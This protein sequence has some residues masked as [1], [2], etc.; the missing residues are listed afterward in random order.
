[1][2]IPV[3][4]KVRY[5]GSA[6]FLP[7]SGSTPYGYFDNDPHF[8]S[9]IVSATKWAAT[10]MGYPIVDIELVDVNFFSRFEEAVLEYG[11]QVNQFNIRNNMYLLQG[12]STSNRVTQKNIQGSGVVYQSS[13]AQD[14]GVELGV[15]G[16]VDWK[17][18][19]FA[20]QTGSDGG[21]R[22]LYDLQAIWGDSVESGSRIEIKRVFHSMPP[23]S[24]RIYDPFSMT[25]MSY[26]N[27]MNEMGFAGYSPATQFLMTPIF[28]DLLRMQAIE[29]NDIVRKS[30][31]SFELVNNKLRI[32]PTPS[33]T[34]NI[35][36]EYVVKKDVIENI[37]FPAGSNLIT[38][39]A[40]NYYTDTQGSGIVGDYSNAPYDIIPF[41]D[42]NS[43]GRQW[44][45]K[46]FLA[47]CKEMLGGIRQKYMTIPIPG[48]EITL[49]G[50]ELRQEAAA[51]KTELINQ[52]RE[53]L[54]ATGRSAQMEK[55]AQQAEQLQ[56]TLKVSPLYIYI[57]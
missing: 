24:A 34:H 51:E 15:G 42:I 39:S 2:T 30:A 36:F 45:N 57:G 6:S 44:I 35:Y 22:Q 18:G 3:Q 40:A 19:H 50:A 28:E 53:N 17:R 16:N 49:D 52:L 41:I 23:A 4:D 26:S 31:Y 9:S 55:Q 21:Y 12:Q 5:P 7:G 33:Y 38:S 56:Q 25:G 8:Q 29:F 37:Y 43:V 48:S 32:F 20:T 1:M 27:I 10:S 13:L 54:E 11:A 14:Y 47:L 46:Y